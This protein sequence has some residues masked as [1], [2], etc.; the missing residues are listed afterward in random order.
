MGGESKHQVL[1]EDKL[2]EISIRAWNLLENLSDTLNRKLKFKNHQL[3]SFTTTAV[4]ELHHMVP[5]NS[6]NF[7]AWILQS[8]HYGETNAHH[9][10]FP[11][12][13]WFHGEINSQNSSYWSSHNPRL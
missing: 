3:K 6:A 12:G 4:H 5:L 10:F 8:V 2:D 9:I 13:A 11:N 7:C 1:K